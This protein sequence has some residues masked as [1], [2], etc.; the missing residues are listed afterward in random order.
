METK[1]SVCFTG[2]FLNQSEKDTVENLT[3]FFSTMKSGEIESLIKNKIIFKKSIDLPLANKI[4]SKFE[5]AGAECFIFIEATEET[6]ST[7]ESEKTI[8]NDSGNDRKSGILTIIASIFL[9]LC[10]LLLSNGY[11]PRG[12]FF[13]SLSET[14]YLYKGHPFGCSEI[15]HHGG[16][17]YRTPDGKL[18]FNYSSMT[19]TG[20]CADSFHF[21]ITTKH[22]LF[23]LLCVAIFGIGRYFSAVKPVKHYW[24]RLRTTLS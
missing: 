11:D 4:K 24:N 9:M 5:L 8:I 3:P 13:W 22:T 2:R 1:Y 17:A 15:K 14:M 20:G 18:S 7:P 12:G 16:E 23:L 6:Q 21:E 19:T 10:T